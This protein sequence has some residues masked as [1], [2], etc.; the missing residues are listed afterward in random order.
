[1]LFVATKSNVASTMLPVDSIMLQAW[2]GLNEKTKMAFFLNQQHVEIHRKPEAFRCAGACV[3]HGR[4]LLK[5][6]VYTR[7]IIAVMIGP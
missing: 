2:A 3:L 1:L 6:D 4:S 5:L 7:N